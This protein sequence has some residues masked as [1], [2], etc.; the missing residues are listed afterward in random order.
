MRSNLA[1]KILGL[2]GVAGSLASAPA[3]LAQEEALS[4]LEEVVVTARRREENIQDVPIAISAFSG[5]DL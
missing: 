1:H 4:I 3:V 5:S 2:A